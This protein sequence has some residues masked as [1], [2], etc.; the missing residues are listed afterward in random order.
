MTD[1]EEKNH[2]L[3]I[4]TYLFAFKRDQINY[5]FISHTQVNISYFQSI[6]N[7][8]HIVIKISTR[9]LYPCTFSL[10]TVESLEVTRRKK[11][12]HMKTCVCS[13]FLFLYTCFNKKYTCYFSYVTHIVL[14]FKFPHFFYFIQ[15][16]DIISLHFYLQDIW[17]FS[18]FYIL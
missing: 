2:D 13:N 3:F 4:Y 8:V 10:I 15:Y 14:V 18:C 5:D 1:F 9:Y 7:L 12:N 17:K 16:G 6:T 11:L